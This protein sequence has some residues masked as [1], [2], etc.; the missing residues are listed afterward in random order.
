MGPTKTPNNIPQRPE[1]QN[2]GCESTAGTK[3]EDNISAPSAPSGLAL[4]VT[5]GYV[6][7]SESESEVE[8]APPRGAAHSTD[9]KGLASRPGQNNHADE[10]DESSGKW[11]FGDDSDEGEDGS[12]G[13]KK[14]E[15]HVAQA[16]VGEK[17]AAA[18]GRAP[19]SGG[20]VDASAEPQAQV[21]IDKL[22]RR[23]NAPSRWAVPLESVHWRR[24]VVR[25]SDRRT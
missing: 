21:A 14:E 18:S 3:A 10:G 5:D 16:S 1:Q 24:T 25:E 2:Q 9:D 22:G 8:S 7:F 20:G 4:V 13:R 17:E 11:D 15:S 19:G 23:G 12:R 6:S